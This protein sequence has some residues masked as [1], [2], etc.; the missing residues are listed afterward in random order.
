MVE[1]NRDVFGV[2]VKSV[3]ATEGDSVFLHISVTEEQRTN[4]IEWRFENDILI[5]KLNRMNNMSTFYN[6][7][8]GGRFRGRLKLDSQTGSLIITNSRST[9]SGLYQVTNINS[10]PLFTF[11]FTVYARLP[12]P[13]ILFSSSQCSSSVQYCSVVCSAVN[14]RSVSLSWYKGNSLLSSISVSDLSSSNSLPLEVEYQNNSTYSCV[15][16]NPI[17]NQTTHL[18][19]NTLCQPCLESCSENYVHAYGFT[20]AVIRLALSAVVGVVTFAMLVYEVRS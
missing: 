12:V 19:I 7:S 11:T 4:E 3:S 18:D 1:G 2:E 16:N 13:D 10:K 17:S 9:D 5:A 20:E 6:D 8:A 14:V 15:V